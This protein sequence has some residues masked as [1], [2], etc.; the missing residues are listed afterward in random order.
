MV[1]DLVHHGSNHAPLTPRGLGQKSLLVLVSTWTG[2][3]LGMLIAVLVARR[4][5]PEAVG[6]LGVGVGLAGIAMALV[7]PG[8]AQAHVKR[9]AE[10]Q[11]AGRCL[12][13]MLTLHAV[14]LVV[15]MPLVIAADA[16]LGTRRTGNVWA[17]FV[18]LLM[19]QFATR[20]A[21]VYLS[22]FLVREWIVEHAAIVVA[23]RIARLVVTAAVLAWA[24]TVTIVAA[25]FVIDGVVSAVAA[26]VVLLVRHGIR[27]RPPTAAMF[28]TYWTYARPLL[29]TNPL[30][31]FQDSIDRV[32]VGR[33]GGLA[34]AGYYHIAR[35]LWE[36]LAS[37]MAAPAMFLFT[38][39]SAMYARR[40][41]SSVDDARRFFFG[42]L[43]KLLFVSIPLAIVLW[44]LADAVIRLLY[45]AAF[46]PATIALRIFVVTTIAAN[47]INPYTH[48][49]YAR[50]EVGRFVP[51]N[52]ARV[53]VYLPTLVALVIADAAGA[54]PGTGDGATGAAMSRLVLMVFPA[55]MYFRWTREIAGI[56][57]Y[58]R[59]WLYAGGFVAAVAVDRAVHAVLDGIGMPPVTTPVA[60]AAALGA[61]IG[62]MLA[63][64]PEAGANLA[65]AR[66]L[67]SPVRVWN[68][69]PWRRRDSLE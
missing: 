63:A 50:D 11:D 37:V 69:L 29:V 33:F 24:P 47:V 57:L 13:T 44:T 54:L 41:P 45:G 30:A 49:L 23:A 39:L 28:R 42:A 20:V 35:A 38:R 60:A 56:G 52:V 22:V 59:V 32:I 64:H 3:L 1:Q 19:A 36:M 53:L 68:S 40:D 10:G 6:A 17:V 2:N 58:R 8:F 27:G 26:G 4:L 5:G 48:I 65:Y 7:L 51:V 34:A 67:V 15:A 43:D 61:Y 46:T 66:S 31:I 18:M 55:W 62:L 14:V 16:T 25:T 9:L 21:D 12:G